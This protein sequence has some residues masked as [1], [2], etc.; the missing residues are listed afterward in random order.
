MLPVGED[1]HELGRGYMEIFELSAH[2]CC[3]LKTDIKIDPIKKKKKNPHALKIFRVL[4]LNQ[5]QTNFP[6][7]TRIKRS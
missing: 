1:L 3:E 4:N 6:E 7:Y 5:L 2:F